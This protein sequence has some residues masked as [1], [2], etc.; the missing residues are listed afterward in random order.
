MICD[1]V[2][3]VLRWLFF[4]LSPVSVALDINSTIKPINNKFINKQKHKYIYIYMFFYFQF[5]LCSPCQTQSETSK[6]LIITLKVVYIRK[7]SLGV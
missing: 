6:K 3:F 7:P 5:S 1:C 4:L 2:W